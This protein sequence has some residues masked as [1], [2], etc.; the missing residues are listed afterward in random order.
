[1]IVGL[2]ALVART[3]N[4]R[5]IYK[6]LVGNLRGKRPVGRPGCAYIGD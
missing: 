4:T 1:M 3:G 6:F 5:N 2:V